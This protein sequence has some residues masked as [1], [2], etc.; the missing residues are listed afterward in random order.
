ML[1]TDYWM[2]RTH[3]KLFLR[4]VYKFWIANANWMQIRISSVSNSWTRFCFGPDDEYE[5]FGPEMLFTD[6]D[7]GVDNSAFDF[8][9]MMRLITETAK[10]V[11]FFPD[12]LAKANFYEIYRLGLPMF[13]PGRQ[14]LARMMISM[15]YY[16]LLARHELHCCNS[17]ARFLFSPFTREHPWGEQSLLK[18]FYWAGF[19]DFVNFRGL[20]VF[21]SIP[22]MFRIMHEVDVEHVRQEMNLGWERRMREA[23]QILTSAV[24]A[25][26]EGRQ[27]R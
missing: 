12:D 18:G 6:Y 9:S 17:S 8:E 1:R 7:A 15:Q 25:L 23:A 20:Q 3:G 16:H 14:Y 27:R 4:L 5:E 24:R 10:G 21:D 19:L 2:E 26:L 13:V 22:E 11:L